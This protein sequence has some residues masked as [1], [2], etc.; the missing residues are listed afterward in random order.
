MAR[1]AG[2]WPLGKRELNI[3]DKNVSFL[4]RNID[5]SGGLLAEMRNRN[6]IT[7]RQKEFVSGE[8]NQYQRNTALFDIIRRNSLTEYMSTIDSLMKTNQEHIAEILRRGGSKYFHLH[9]R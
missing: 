6:T 9:E 3:I 8:P 1:F 4:K 7:E 2:E 5:T